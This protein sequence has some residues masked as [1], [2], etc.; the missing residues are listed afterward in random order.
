V[1]AAG[2]AV[3]DQRALPHGHVAA[4]IGVMRKLDL[5]RLLGRTLSRERDLALA[6][7]ASRLVAPSS[8]L[9]TARAAVN[10]QLADGAA[11]VIAASI[12]APAVT[13][14][15]Q[16]DRAVVHHVGQCRDSRPSGRTARN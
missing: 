14:T 2:G 3:R 16:I 1:A 12:D 6:M 8:K 4:V 11:P 13:R 7:I 5:P 10:A 9:A 15:A